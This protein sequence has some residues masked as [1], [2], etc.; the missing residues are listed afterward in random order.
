MDQHNPLIRLV[1]VSCEAIQLVIRVP[2]YEVNKGFLSDFLHYSDDVRVM[3]AQVALNLALA[4][5]CYDYQLDAAKRIAKMNNLQDGPIG[6]ALNLSKATDPCSSSALQEVGWLHRRGHAYTIYQ[7]P[8]DPQTQDL[9]KWLILCYL[10]STVMTGVTRWLP[11]LGESLSYQGLM[12]FR[13]KKLA[14]LERAAL[15]GV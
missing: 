12:A 15:A 5:L 2:Y 8:T 6:A 3:D 11:T 9:V 14:E 7:L 1:K 10:H 4:E 13:R